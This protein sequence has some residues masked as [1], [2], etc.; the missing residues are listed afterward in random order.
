[1]DEFSAFAQVRLNF[2]PQQET[3]LKVIFWRDPE[4]RVIQVLVG[5]KK[6]SNSFS[7]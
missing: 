2:K 6:E 4:K 1:M 5:F 3:T 7:E